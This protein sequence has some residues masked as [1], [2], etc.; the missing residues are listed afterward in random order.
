MVHRDIGPNN[1]VL[2]DMPPPTPQGKEGE[3]EGKAGQGEKS[4]DNHI[5][6]NRSK[7]GKVYLV[8]F[9]AVLETVT[10]SSPQSQLLGST[11]IGGSYGFMSPEQFQ[12]GRANQTA[13]V[14]LYG[15]GAT[16]LYL[17][18]GGKNPSFFPQVRL[19]VQ[20]RDRVVCGRRLADVVEGLL[21]PLPEDRMTARQAR[22]T[23]EGRPYTYPSAASSLSSSSIIPATASSSS[24][25]VRP[26]AI[27]YPSSRPSSMEDENDDVNLALENKRNRILPQPF[28][29]LSRLSKPAGSRVR[30]TANESSIT[31]DIPAKGWKGDTVANG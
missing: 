5:N 19:K 14:D 2:V 6:S 27:R 20:F 29:P 11:I 25:S 4:L 10:T 13:A 12:G 22:D 3:R 23:L 31:V 16:L 9:G 21:E 18:S 7:I 30:I 28:T 8:D 24:R 17:L 1:L 26:S 15:L